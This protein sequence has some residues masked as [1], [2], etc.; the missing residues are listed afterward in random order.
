M[1]AS[2]RHSASD[3][4]YIGYRTSPG[5]NVQYPG[6]SFE[7]SNYTLLVEKF[8]AGW[9]HG[10][11][12]NAWTLKAYYQTISNMTVYETDSG[13]LHLADFT[14]PVFS[15]SGIGNAGRGS[16]RYY[17]LEASFTRSWNNRWHIEANQSLLQ[18]E[19]KYSTADWSPGKFNTGFITHAAVSREIIRERNDK[20]RIWNFSLR[21]IVQGGFREPVISET[22]SAAYFQ[23]VYDDAYALDN[24]LAIYKRIDLGIYR[25]ITTT[26][27][28]WRY[29]LDIQNAFGFTNEA[30]H[31]FDPFLDRIETKEH[32]G[33][34][35]V[36]SVQ[37]SW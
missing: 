36:L 27:F 37:L 24:K 2:L 10:D 23:T 18:A 26:R 11:M 31:Y 32:L 20:N 35:P 19:R 17:G 12:K 5:Q 33:I 6:V 8:E 1:Q 4:T 16:A 9:Q 14:E 34:I 29:A 7:P 13:I 25:T 28:R 3:K 15:L 22:A 30:Y 21:G